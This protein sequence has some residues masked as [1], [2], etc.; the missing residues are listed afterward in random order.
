MR[1]MRL[2]QHRRQQP[3]QYDDDDDLLIGK[4]S[5]VTYESNWLTMRPNHV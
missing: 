5:I 4:G 3:S 2:A 1:W